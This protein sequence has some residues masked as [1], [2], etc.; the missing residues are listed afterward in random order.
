[1][2]QAIIVHAAPAVTPR[3][4]QC[5]MET[6]ICVRC[7]SYVHVPLFL[8]TECSNCRAEGSLKCQAG[9]KSIAVITRDGRFDLSNTSFCCLKCL[10]IAEASVEVYLQSGF[11]PGC[12]TSL[13]YLFST[14]VL[15]HWTHLKD[16]LP[17]SSERKYLT[18]LEELSKTRGRFDVISRVHF[19]RASR[20]YEYMQHQINTKILS[21]QVMVCK[22]YGVKPKA[23]HVDGNFKLYRWRLSYIK[24]RSRSLF[25]SDIIHSDEDVKSHVESIDSVKPRGKGKDTCG[26]SAYTAGRLESNRKKNMDQT[27]VLMGSC[28]H[29]VILGA[30]NMDRGETYRHV[31]FLNS[32]ISC[33]FFCQ[34]VVCKYFPFAEEIGKTKGLERFA[35]YLGKIR[36]LG[37]FHAQVKFGERPHPLHPTPTRPYQPLPPGVHIDEKLAFYETG[38]YSVAIRYLPPS[39]AV[40]VTNLQVNADKARY[41]ESLKPEDQ[42]QPIVVVKEEQIYPHIPLPLGPLV[43]PTPTLAPRLIP[44]PLRSLCP[45][46]YRE[47]HP[48]QVRPVRTILVSN[49][50]AARAGVPDKDKKN[51]KVAIEDHAEG[52]VV[53]VKREE[54]EEFVLQV[55][56]S[57]F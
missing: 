20:E 41:L 28:R 33:D 48:P 19:A 17:G 36:R 16:Q 23:L 10:C 40:A 32:K 14:D 46:R 26:D 6:T 21:R 47:Q 42:R 45:A 54:E 51:V 22:A 53:T 2:M 38:F 43:H 25:N 1:M 5:H 56:E 24:D 18:I 9:S 57:E 29:G 50:F 31:H 49:I 8:P 11:W 55:L 7:A 15:E 4:Q 37:E 34:D 44:P 52:Q 30:A 27:G 3:C 39:D 35:Q 13:T 12:P